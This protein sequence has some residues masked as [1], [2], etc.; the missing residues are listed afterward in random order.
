MTE[1]QRILRLLAQQ[2]PPSDEE[3]LAGI[4]REF[5]AG[6]KRREMLTVSAIMKIMGISSAAPTGISA[7]TAEGSPM[8]PNLLR[9]SHMDL[10]VNWLTRRLS[11]FSVVRLPSDV[12]TK[13]FLG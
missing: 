12:R 10:C 4:V 9:K 8:K 3:I 5:L 13:P 6:D 1:T 2:S 7:R 11:T